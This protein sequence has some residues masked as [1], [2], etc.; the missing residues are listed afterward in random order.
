MAELIQKQDTL[1]EGREKLNA[2]ITD[3]EK[4]KS[5]SEQANVVSNQ[6][7][8]I[9]QS[10]ESKSDYTQQQLDNIIIE[11]GTSDAETIQARGDYDLLYKRLDASDSTMS[12][13]NQDLVSRGVNVLLSGVIGD[14]I[15]DD[16]S[17]LRKVISENNVIVIPIPPNYYKITDEIV[18]PS[19]KTVIFFGGNMWNPVNKKDVWFKYEGEVALGKAM[20]R[21]SDSPCGIEPDVARSNIKM[22]GG[23]TLDGNNK[24]GH[25][26]Y[27]AY[28]VNDSSFSAITVIRTLLDGYKIEKSWYAT[29]SNLVA[30]NTQGPGITIGKNESWGGVNGVEFRSLRASSCGLN[31][32]FDEANPSAGGY[33]I[34]FFPGSGTKLLNA[35]SESNYGAGFVYGT[36]N[37]PINEVD[38][39]YL[40]GNGIGA[41]NDGKASRNWGFVV[42]GSSSGRGNSV[43]N[44][45]MFGPVG[46]EAAQSLLITGQE[47]VS[48]IEF[49]NVSFG[50][51]L[52]ADWSNYK[53]LGYVYDGLTQY[54]DG[55]LP[56]NEV[57][58]SS[59]ITTVY[60]RNS[61][62]DR[63]DG[64]TSAT[65]VRSLKR[66]LD[67]VKFAPNINIIDCAGTLD[68]EFID[69]RNINKP[70]TFDGKTTGRIVNS[71]NG[72]SLDFKNLKL[73][74]HR[75]NYRKYLNRS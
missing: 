35:T 11:S 43:R 1:N 16:T 34:G 50:H 24:I 63:N 58:L 28:V 27:S 36:G 8:T 60:V 66:A 64:R 29:Y 53:M 71:T 39:V 62:N 12:E 5:S 3:A 44:L 6:A 19:N 23:V 51:H 26:F 14:G 49:Y 31:G 37:R 25:G 10:A 2:A 21:I 52:K 4:A 65:A 30:R 13:N 47:P 54:I 38:T 46:N 69:F 17:A 40:E 41:K 42:E 61:G 33:G 48:P 22:Y 59:L 20:F 15:T 74:M 57:L 73:R 72:Q 68:V 70:V 7:V 55:H 56:K 45:F 75:R 9:A 67:I 18:F 32:H